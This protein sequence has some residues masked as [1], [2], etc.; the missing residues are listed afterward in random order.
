MVRELAKLVLVMGKGGVGK[1]T[2]AR[3]IAHDFA[4][5]GLTCAALDLGTGRG[6]ATTRRDDG[7]R[8]D[9]ISISEDA[10][11][12]EAGSEVFGSPRVAKLVLGNA[13][14]RRLLG[15]V[16]GVREYCLVVAARARLSEYDRV[17]VDMPAT[18][19][20]VAWLSAA[21]QL[22]RLVPAGRARSQAEALDA[23][24][25]D[26][27]Q[28]SYVLV[29]LPEPMVRHE[30]D[31][32]TRALAERLG[33]GIDLTVLNRIPVDPGRAEEAARALAQRDPAMVPALAELLV[34]TRD[35]QGTLA[36]ARALLE[37]S[38]TLPLPEC[39]GPPSLAVMARALANAGGAR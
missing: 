34:W 31:E 33:V 22:A 1:S 17:V 21:A 10:A 2:A 26:P 4:Q 35:R 20:G 8:A 18:G 29:T 32:L 16:P 6:V 14:I 36:R 13:A 9:T 15:V 39:S 12:L 24:L 5:R 38:S 19:H 7:L 25:R 3:G 23:A 37:G 30:S 28:T 27:R 11:L